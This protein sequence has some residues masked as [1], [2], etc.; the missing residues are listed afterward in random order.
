MKAEIYEDP[1]K[2]EI[3]FNGEC[4]ISELLNQSGVHFSMPCGGKHLCKKCKV[5]LIGKVSEP[6]IEELT[7]LTPDEQ[8]GGIRFACMTKALSDVQIIL[9]P[10]IP[11]NICADISIPAIK[12]PIGHKLG[13][14]IDIG[15]TTIASCLYDIPSQKILDKK[16]ALNPE[17]FFGD[18]VLN[19]LE[20]SLHT[21][22]VSK[23]IKNCLTD[24]VASYDNH[25][26][27]DSVVISGNTAMLYLLFEIDAR[28]LLE[29]P[30]EVTHKFGKF[31][32]NEHLKLPIDPN[33]R[34]YI[35]PCISAFIGADTVSALISLEIPSDK[36]QLFIDMGTNGEIV[37]S[38]D[39]QLLCT[40]TALGPAFEGIGITCGSVACD[41]AIEAIG[42]IGGHFKYKVIGGNQPK[43]I[44]A[45]GL[46][47]LHALLLKLEIIDAFGTFNPNSNYEQYIQ[48][49]HSEKYFVLENTDIILTQSDIRTLQLAKSA[50]KTGID[51]LL[52]EC[53]ISIDNLD[54][55][56]L[57]GG[58]AAHL[59]IDNCITIG[60]LPDIP[61]EK[62]ILKG[63]TSLSGA[64]N[65][66][67]NKNAADTAKNTAE[68]ADTI[69]LNSISYFNDSFIENMNF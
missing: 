18:D 43:S 14:A 23:S 29:P 34:I 55:I 51:V 65:F 49:N 67:L 68:N 24:L 13:L 19:R 40:S 48:E 25:Q 56:I 22:D 60:L 21:S 61:R 6:S 32:D 41:G 69:D 37:L 66:L 8:S 58:F 33:A 27:I 31:I 42:F 50:V 62:F 4:L 39:R 54:Q 28:K 36:N 11:K 47:D 57:S 20:K 53:K 59:N 35:P 7:F 38:K 44:C 63:N 5:K 1:L 30:F 15:T 52:Q 64:L 45:S 16:S 2:K 10:E 3:E 9:N 46:I 26:A 17:R 12:N